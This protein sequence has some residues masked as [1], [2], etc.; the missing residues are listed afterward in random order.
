MRWRW[1]GSDV[2]SHSPYGY[3]ATTAQETVMNYDSSAESVFPGWG[4]LNPGHEEPDCSPHPF[5]VMA[6]YALYGH[7]P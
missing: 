3:H 7:V 4:V 5:D 2:D 1:K 6:I